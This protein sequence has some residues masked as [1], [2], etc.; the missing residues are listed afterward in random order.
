MRIQFTSPVKKPNVVKKIV[1]NADLVNHL[2]VLSL[3]ST[4][5]PEARLAL[6]FLSALLSASEAG[7]EFNLR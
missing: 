1:K 3:G 2:I 6:T 4:P 7:L 5:E